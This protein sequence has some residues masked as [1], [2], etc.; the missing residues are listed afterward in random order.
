MKLTEIKDENDVIEYV[1]Q[2]DYKDSKANAINAL[3]AMPIDQ[4]LS[5]EERMSNLRLAFALKGLSFAKNGKFND[6]INLS[7]YQDEIFYK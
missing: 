2:F 1:T 4:D 7:K 5:L 3:G 6:M